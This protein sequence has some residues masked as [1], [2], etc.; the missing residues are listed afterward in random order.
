MAKTKGNVRIKGSLDQ[1]TF[2]QGPDGQMVRLRGGVTPERIATDPIFAMT[3]ENGAEFGESAKMGKLLRQSIRPM[4]MTS[5]DGKVTSRIT[6]LMAK[7]KNLDATSIRGERKVALG[8]ATPAGKLLFQGMDLNVKAPLGTVLFK[9][10]A[11]DTASGKISIAGLNPTRDIS[12]P[13]GATVVILQG[14]WAKVDFVTGVYETQY[15]NEEE[16]AIVPVAT[17]VLL[18]PTAVPAGPGVSFFVLEISFGQVVNGLTYRMKNRSFNAVQ[19]VE[20]I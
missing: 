2:Y 6:A 20:V 8:L 11:L 3:R 16:L 12:V 15:T 13:T 9:P 18:T 4:I 10:F 19:I 14:A 5:A 17:N 1:W 7:V